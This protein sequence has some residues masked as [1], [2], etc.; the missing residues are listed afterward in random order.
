VARG[1]AWWTQVREATPAPAR[2]FFWP[3]LSG[4]VHFSSLIY[5]SPFCAPRSVRCCRLF[6]FR[7]LL[8]SLCKPWLQIW[9]LPWR[10]GV[11]RVPRRSSSSFARAHP[12]ALSLD[13]RMI[14]GKI[15]DFFARKPL[16]ARSR[17][18]RCPIRQPGAVC[19]VDT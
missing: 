19:D 3:L 9:H 16:H 12:R 6:L 5:S 11:A 17:L 18:F 10:S 7:P 1:A 4:G 14:L 2:R 8:F 13:C 15:R